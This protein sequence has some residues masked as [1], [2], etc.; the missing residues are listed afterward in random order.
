MRVLV[1][2]L[3]LLLLSFNSYATFHY[4]GKVTL[5]FLSGEQRTDKFLLSLTRE[6]GS[7]IFQ[8]G[9]QSARLPSPPQKY[10]LSVVLQQEREVWISDFA[11]QPLQAFT[12]E[13]AEHKIELKRAPQA[14]TARGGF[15]IQYG[16]EEFFFGRGPAQINFNLKQ[17]GIVD[18]EIRGMFKPRR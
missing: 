9:S 2:V 14:T 4:E 8:V 11:K 7:Y 12:L 13:I 5:H 3:V 18:I 10:A 15:V 17:S 1:L 6:S 16:N